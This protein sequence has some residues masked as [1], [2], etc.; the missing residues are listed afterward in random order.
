MRRAR[1]DK[2]LLCLLLLSLITSWPSHVVRADEPSQEK[3][4][5]V[6]TVPSEPKPAQE[7]TEVFRLEEVTVT[8]T[9]EERRS[10][11]VPSAVT[12]VEHKSV[13]RQ[14][15]TVLPDLLRG[16]T[17]VYVQETT[18]G[19]AAPIIRGL[20]GSSVLMLVD[21]MRLNTA[22]FRSAPNQYFAL[23]DPYNVERIEVV[24]EAGSTL[25]G[26]DAMGGVVNVITPVPRFTT[27]AWQ[28]HSRALGE[29]SSADIS[30]VT[31][32]AVQGGRR[33]IAISSGF[34]FQTH[35]DLRGGRDTGV[36]EPSGFKVYAADGKVF[37]TGESQDLLLS[38]QY[39]VQPKTP[40]FDELVPGFG[41]TEPSAAVFFFEPNDRLFLH[42]RYRLHNPFPFLDRLEFNVAFQEINDDRRARDFGSTREDRERNRSRLIGLTLQLT[43]HWKDWMILTYGGEIYL[44]KT[45]SSRIGRNIETGETS[46]RQ[47][48]FADGST[49]DSFAFYLQDE[50]RL[51]PQLTAILGG[52]FSY[53]DIDIPKA[54]REVGANLNL[55]DLTGSLGLIYRLI[56]AI[57][58]VTN[59][60]RGFR[61]PNV[62]DLSTLGPRP[63]NRFNIPNP[64]LDSEKVITVDAGVKVNLPRFTGEVFG[65]Y[66]AFQD[67]IED[68]PTGETTPEGRL[69]VQSVN[70]NNVTLFGAEAGGRLRLL[71]N[72]ELFGSLTF[73]WGEEEFPDGRTTP[74]DRIPP[75]NGRVGLLYLPFPRLWVEPFVRFATTQDRLS[76]RD[77]TDPRINPKG[78]PGWVTTNLRLGW[79]LHPNLKA[80]LT[81]ENLFDL[82]YREHGSGINA[83]GLNAVASLEARF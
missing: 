35:D 50:I 63:G 66:S 22:F 38:V 59:V 27:E 83:P 4:E 36:Q 31:R 55:S 10:F 56:P 72:V 74:A 15:P 9:R 70:L 1:S 68:V 45:N 3:P 82:D 76:D 7:K 49:L 30:W 64:N 60:G 69:V 25:Y 13:A 28:L 11:D 16:E 34:T 78:T 24:R 5:A 81:L 53:F 29:F 73:T 79:D 67:K 47:S 6:Q 80:R 58:L 23:V 37:F 65:F 71:D 54:D 46:P 39:L 40:R 61:V 43:S 12:V 41:Q 21:G 8:A 51:H 75:L 57:H 26:S 14:S 2:V 20:I 62:F 42:G 52:R 44:D 17:G 77:R 18:P 48:R 19:Q 33:G 32:L